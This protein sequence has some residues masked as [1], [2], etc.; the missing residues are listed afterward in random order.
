MEFQ[1]KQNNLGINFVG[2]DLDCLGSNRCSIT[3]QLSGLG[4]LQKLSELQFS[5]LYYNKSAYLLWFLIMKND[6]KHAEFC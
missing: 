6:N 4:S 2:I 3:H 5:H 1:Q